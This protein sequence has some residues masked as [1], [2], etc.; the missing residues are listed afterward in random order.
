MSIETEL[1]VAK[2]F[3]MAVIEALDVVTIALRFEAETGTQ[4][5][6]RERA[7]PSERAKT[8]ENFWVE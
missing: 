8:L 7:K 1:T 6:S 2:R 3:L 4:S 5:A